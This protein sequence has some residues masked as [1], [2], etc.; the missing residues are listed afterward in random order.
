M[1]RFFNLVAF[2]VIFVLIAF[3][4]ED[5][6]KKFHDLRMSPLY[7]YKNQQ[8]HY[9]SMYVIDTPG[10]KIPNY[11][12]F[13]HSIREKIQ[14]GKFMPCK[15]I[16]SIVKQK[17]SC[18]KIDRVALNKSKYKNSFS[19]C[20]VHTVYRPRY[21][22][23][24]N[25]VTYINEQIFTNETCL[26][27]DM[28]RVQ[29]FD[30]K[31]VTIH[32][33][34]FWIYQKN[35]TLE[36]QCD[37]RLRKRSENSDVAETL[38]VL[39]LGVDSTSRLN[40]QRFFV[41]TRQALKQKFHSVEF[42]GQNILGMDTFT[43]VVPLLTGSSIFELKKDGKFGSTPMDSFDFIWK[44]FEQNGY[45]TLYAED[46]AWMAVFDYV[47]P[48]FKNFPTH[49]YNRPWSVAWE[50]IHSACIGGRSEPEAIM[51]Y[52][53]KFVNVY[54]SKPYF[55]FA[56]I[57]SLTHDSQ[58]LSAEADEIMS[59]FFHKAFETNA[60]NNTIVFFF[61]DHG[62]RYGATRSS[63]IGSYEVQS[64]MLYIIIPRWFSEKYKT[65]DNNLRN[66][67]NKLTTMY[68]LHATLRNILNFSGEI[69]EYSFPQR[70]ES[71]FSEVSDVRNCSDVGVPSSMCTCSQYEKLDNF[72]KIYAEHN[73][74]AI[75][76][77]KLNNLL[78]NHQTICEHLT[79]DKTISVYKAASIKR[80]H[81][82]KLTIRTLPGKALFEAA[83]GFDSSKNEYKVE[84]I[85]RINKY[86]DQSKCVNDYMLRNYCFCKRQ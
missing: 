47:K 7:E 25:Y 64:P 4:Y 39:L 56:F 18:I 60:F 34:F 35:E 72:S 51:E 70:G 53:T 22:K 31:N 16:P 57:T 11:E 58:E 83:V 79:L 75:V 62:L 33:N 48:G 20:R 27:S 12:A 84:Q 44:E 42:K 77:T 50:S 6:L 46:A 67:A 9:D 59:I 21:G 38:S 5:G 81:V 3:F 43:N 41:K 69:L 19:F 74:S 68:D 86:G 1:E 71:L 65:I 2:L 63:D 78:K 13:D 30:N 32:T 14:P 73:L 80:L 40:A 36:K 49:F 52:M 85:L 37:E 26:K 55:A 82:F 24:H 15:T 54:K 29:C 17:S 76:V 66:N 61:G 45:R 10:C 8:W 23:D 28:V